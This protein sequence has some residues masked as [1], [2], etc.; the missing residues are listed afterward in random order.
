VITQLAKRS[1]KWLIVAVTMVA[2]AVAALLY[3]RREIAIDSCLDLGGRWNY[4]AKE[5]EGERRAK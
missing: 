5:C 4:A 3:F 2:V 1:R